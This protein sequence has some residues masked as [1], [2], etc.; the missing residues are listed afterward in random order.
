ML[1]DFL[2]GMNL[3]TTYHGLFRTAVKCEE[4]GFILPAEP[5][6]GSDEH[7]LTKLG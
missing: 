4:T 6:K 5:M 7:S 1:V 3:C 2:G